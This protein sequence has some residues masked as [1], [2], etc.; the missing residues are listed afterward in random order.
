LE[1]KRRTI[2]AGV[3]G[4]KYT[5]PPAAAGGNGIA[6]RDR[7]QA[8]NT[9]GCGTTKHPL[10]V[11][12]HSYSRPYGA[13]NPPL[14]ATITGLL[15]GDIITVTKSTTA[16]AAS[17]VGTYPITATVSG[18]ALANY[19]IT[20]VDGTLTV[21]PAPLTVT[22][23]NVGRLYGAPNPALGYFTTGLVNGDTITVA[24]STTA[25]PSSPVGSYPITANVTGAALA[26]YTLTVAPGTLTVR[27]ATLHIVAVAAVSRY[28]Q[29]PPQPTAYKL[30]G[31]VNG[32][33]A[34]I[35]TGAPILS[36]TV[37]STTPVGF[38]KIGIQTGTLAAPNYVFTGVSN[39][40]GSVQVLRAPLQLKANNLTMTQGSTV[41]TLTYTLTGFVN[42]QSAAGTVTGTPDLS[43]T[44]TSASRPG[45]YPITIK[46][47]TLNSTNYYFQNVNGTITVNP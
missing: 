36:T 27:P 11:T 8:T 12:V 2:S 46:P 16:T 17:P 42:G 13:A 24:E 21:T 41:P 38:Y 28:G 9:P 43:T 19:N 5:P 10:T 47:A 39:G 45:H 25:T 26:N 14:N 32:D 15:N 23:R 6:F 18:A 44:A 7:I 3:L 33:T 20:L 31:F 30:T 37:T 4:P 35:V 1:S 40:E 34:G 22:L 29:P